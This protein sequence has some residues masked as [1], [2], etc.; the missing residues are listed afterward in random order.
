M[1]FSLE[2]NRFSVAIIRM[3]MASDCL[4]SL[5]INCQLLPHS[6]P[7]VDICRLIMTHTRLSREI[8][9]D[10]GPKSTNWSFCTIGSKQE[11]KNKVPLSRRSEGRVCQ[12]RS[13]LDEEY[14]VYKEKQLW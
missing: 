13:K 5:S 1:N 11:E 9:S 7:I 6:V 4:W 14:N 2:E 3:C 12:S 8:L 10:Y